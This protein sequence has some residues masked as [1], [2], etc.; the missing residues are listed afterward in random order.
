MEIILIIVIILVV[1][2][3]LAVK[4]IPTEGAQAPTTAEE[5]INNTTGLELFD[6]DKN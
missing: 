3:V 5:F 6:T 2:V 4:A 1:L